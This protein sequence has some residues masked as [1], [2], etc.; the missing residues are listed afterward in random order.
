MPVARQEHAQERHLGKCTRNRGGHY[1][2]MLIGAFLDDS[3]GELQDQR[4]YRFVLADSR[5]REAS[6]KI[7]INL[8]VF[9]IH[10]ETCMCVI[11]TGL[12]LAYEVLL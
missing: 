5:F 2:W 7:R 4:R 11:E 10:L 12:I 1:S 9:K 3:E 8:D 6:D